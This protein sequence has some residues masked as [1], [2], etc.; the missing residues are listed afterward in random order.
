MLRELPA[1]RMRRTK[2]GRRAAAAISLAFAL[3]AS[4]QAQNYPARP[5]TLVAPY[6]AGGGA[7]LVARLLA[8]KLSDRLGQP[9]VVENRLGAGGVIAAK[10]S[11]ERRVGKEWRGRWRP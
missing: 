5:V 4:A 7:D 6:A 11:E 10:R 2:P 9:F 8:Q 3:A 1:R